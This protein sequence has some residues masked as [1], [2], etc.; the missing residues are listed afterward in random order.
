MSQHVVPTETERPS[1]ESSGTVLVIDDSPTSMEFD[2]L[3][4]EEVGY[5]VLSAASG[6]EGL[7]I[8]ARTLPDI[9]L[10]DILMPGLDGY[11]VCRRIRTNPALC[12]IPVVMVTALGDQTDK[13]AG[14]QA[15]A[16]DFLT[17]PADPAEL[18][19][20]VR[21]LVHN[22]RLQQSLANSEAKYRGLIER[23]PLITYIATADG[24]ENARY[25]YVSP[26]IEEVLGF[27]VAEWQA[28]PGMW[29]RQMHPEDRDRLRRTVKQPGEVP[30]EQR[31]EDIEFRL[32]SKMGVEVWFKGAAT[33]VEDPLT[34]ELQ[35]HG[36]LVDNSEKK[37]AEL[38]KQRLAAAIEHEHERL[39][40]IIEGMSDGLLVLDQGG[41]VRYANT[42]ASELLGLDSAVVIGK[43]LQ[44]L[45]KGV[46]SDGRQLES[47][48]TDLQ[49]LGEHPT[50]ALEILGPPSRDLRGLLF[51]L[52]GQGNDA[53][54]VGLLLRDVTRE[55]DLLRAKDQLLTAVSQESYQRVQALNHEL[56]RRVAI[57]EAS[58]D[59]IIGA[60]ADGFVT[61]WNPAAEVMFGTA[62]LEAIGQRIS[63]LS[64]AFM[65]P[66]GQHVIPGIVSRVM[67][68][69]RGE[70]HELEAVRN[71]GVHLVVSFAMSPVVDSS[72]NVTGIVAVMRDVTAQK[73][74]QEAQ[75]HLAAIVQSAGVAIV[76]N[77]LTGLVT[78]WN[79]GAERLYGYTASE[80]IGQPVSII[81]PHD[82]QDQ[83][84]LALERI[85]EGLPV[86]PYEA[87]RVR[88]DGTHATVFVTVSPIRDQNGTIVS[89]AAITRDI[90][91][92]K[93]AEG[94]IRKLNRELEERVAQRTADLLE[95]NEELNKASRLKSEFLANMS[96]ELRTP[97]NAII[98]FSE[99]LL[100]PE[101]N[102]VE[103]EK[104]DQFVGNIHRS[105]K[106]LLSLINDILDLSKVEAGRMELQYE[107]LALGPL[108]QGCV[109]IVTPLA[110]KKN[111][112]LSVTCDPP[113][114]NLR[115]DAAKVK[116]ILYNLLSNG[117]KFTPEGGQ[118][119]VIASLSDSE[120]RI[121]V[122]D[123]GIGIAPEDQ[124]RVFEA[125]RQIE[126]GTARQQ[127][128][129][130]LGLALVKRFVELHGGQITLKSS[131][132]HGSSF[133][134]TLPLVDDLDLEQARVAQVAPIARQESPE[135]LGLPILVVE[136]EAEAAQ[137][138]SIYLTQGGYQVHTVSSVNEALLAIPSVR[139]VAVMLDIMLPG[140][141]GWE[142]LTTL[143]ADPATKDLA[144]IV[145]T[146]VDNSTLGFALGAT[147]YMVKPIE[148]T[149]LL[150]SIARIVQPR[151]ADP[152]T[153]TS[154]TKN[155]GRGE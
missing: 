102:R 127:E 3:A 146:I 75:A 71:D 125:F 22:K 85:R 4:L 76:G 120:A 155:G 129:T 48:R 18:V 82:Q 57:I 116:Q 133:T 46:V 86:E 137:L 107:T 79:P 154:S 59:A 144:V 2:R 108:L 40:A 24:L 21:C 9:I 43:K 97:L 63:D 10:L 61:S 33:T 104:R 88:K 141:E 44:P 8:A 32:L 94:A 47:W 12:H 74:A 55:L 15:G 121:A 149:A 105:G 106:H 25:V 81:V 111:I 96:H 28:Q 50:L 69:K 91:A 51:A 49:R 135:P 53:M 142:L 42:K 100:D 101:L 103:T 23:L 36:F 5:E 112:R 6:A 114:G 72:G 1:G 115:A 68:A 136:D 122:H 52:P 131:L 130:G 98:G 113:H 54:D 147:D 64:L 148:K 110:D 67:A 35:V 16:N 56:E 13:L 39:T 128:G 134:F 150:D 60:S 7:D 95:A 109:A 30:V 27:S 124:E 99:V 83:P 31:H 117:V 38:E 143:R 80:M 152:S 70:R 78:S 153:L 132:G 118:V 151:R 62:S 139:P 126:Q 14:L 19:A 58:D 29:F 92:Q 11:E 87:V 17:K 77:S 90:T 119:S 20:R 84:R 145:V 138:L 37:R 65:P 26:Q 45:L 93:D 89:A 73:K 66:G 41:M 34:G 123:S 140:R